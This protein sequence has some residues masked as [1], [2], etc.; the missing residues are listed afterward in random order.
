MDSFTIRNHK[1]E[2]IFE[3]DCSHEEAFANAKKLARETEE[4]ESIH[5]Y[6]NTVHRFSL[7]RIEGLTWWSCIGQASNIERRTWEKVAKNA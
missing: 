1:M 2:V 4:Y 3:K 5:L 6:R 7:T